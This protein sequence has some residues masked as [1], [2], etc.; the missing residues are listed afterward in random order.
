VVT[1]T[2]R[3]YVLAVR[4]GRIKKVDV[5]TG[6]ESENLVEAYGY[7]NMGDSIIV[8]ANEEIKEGNLAN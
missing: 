4:S 6:N 3:K 8:N 2:E 7:L 5:T 1:S